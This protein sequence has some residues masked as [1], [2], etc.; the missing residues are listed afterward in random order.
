MKL[1]QFILSSITRNSLCNYT[2]YLLSF[3]WHFLVFHDLDGFEKYCV[4]CLSKGICLLL[5]VFIFV[6]AGIESRSSHRQDM[7]YLW[8]TL[9]SLF[10]IPFTVLL[11]ITIDGNHKATVSFSHLGCILTTWLNSDENNFEYSVNIVE[12][13]LSHSI[14]ILLKKVW[15]QPTFKGVGEIMFQFLNSTHLHRLS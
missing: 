7:L 14:L 13:Y 9:P 11:W 3:F 4:L 8:A 15:A 12:I 5:L 2:L 1:F 10:F 6:V